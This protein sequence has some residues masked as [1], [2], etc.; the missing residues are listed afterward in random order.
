MSSSGV[1]AKVARFIRRAAIPIVLCWVALAAFVN[2]AVPPLEVVGESRAVAVTPPDAPSMVALRH[3]GE[4]FD[5]SH[6][7]SIAMVV[8]EGAQP[9][10]AD[11]H[12]YYDGL[13]K[14]I[15]ADGDH[16]EHVQDLWSDPLTARTLS[17]GVDQPNN[18][19]LKRLQAWVGVSPIPPG[20]GL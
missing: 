5:E 1:H 4:V 8:L 2:I 9:L 13:V 6:S 10:G 18:L 20:F 15:R 12:A 19:D 7:N 16:V 11:A 17:S 14:A 3:D